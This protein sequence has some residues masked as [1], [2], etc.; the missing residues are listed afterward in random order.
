[1]RTKC[2]FSESMRLPVALGLMAAVLLPAGTSFGRHSNSVRG[3]QVRRERAE[4]EPAAR[5]RHV[6]VGF[7]PRAAR[8]LN[9]DPSIVEIVLVAHEGVTDYGNPSHAPRARRTRV[10]AYN[11]SVPGPT[12]VGNVGDRL[13]VHFLNFLPEP[14]T[15]HWHGMEVPANMDGSNI[16]QGEV[17]SGGYFRYEFDLLAAATYWYHPHLHSNS[18]IEM[19]L[20]GMVVVRDPQEDE[21]IPK[22]DKTVILD[23]VLLDEDEQ[24]AEEFPADPLLRAETMLNG[25]EGN[26]LLV[27]GRPGRVL[28]V[29]I[30]VPQRWRIV[31][32]AN[33]RFMRLSI[34]GHTLFRIGGD[35][36]LLEE[37][38]AIPEVPTIANPDFGMDMEPPFISDPDPAKGLLLSI[39]E[40]ADVVFVPQGHPGDL[41]PVQWHDWARGLHETFYNLDGSIGFGHAHHDGKRPPQ[42]LIWLRLTAGHPVALNLPSPLRDIEPIDTT[43]AAP[44]KVIFGHAAPDPNGDVT[45]FAQTHNLA[46]PPAGGMPRP[47]DAVTPDIAQDVFVGETRIWEITN[48][49]GSDHPFHVH[50]WF[51]QPIEVQFFDMA[52]PANNMTVPYSYL[53]NKDTLLIPQRP[54]ALGTSRTVVRAAVFFGDEGREGQVAASG[55]TPTETESGGWV[56][57]CHIDEHADRGMMSFFEVFNP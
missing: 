22:N 6:A 11:G 16:A 46:L 19:G 12:I 2:A 40:R 8:D 15:I 53:E 43:G 50:G 39:A 37:A 7:E 3:P 34:P 49:T 26:L 33:A 44:L 27:N 29:P 30:G 5:G 38:I 31:N 52:N 35:G 10:Y 51:F 32:V 20:Y 47:F 13:I 54:G 17:P 36:G 42:T 48:L 55:K 23:D 41:I 56:F 25:R 21:A 4:R 18:Q 28:D 57:H 9:P 24:V 14:T 45:F 1:M